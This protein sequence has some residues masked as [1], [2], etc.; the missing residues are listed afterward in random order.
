MRD[1]VRSILDQGRG[2]IGRRDHPELGSALDWA[3]RRGELVAVLAG[4]YATPVDAA[5]LLT[6]ARAARLRDPGC[7]VV[8]ESAAVLM[9]WGEVPEPADLQVASTR[10][11]PHAGFRVERRTIPRRLVR[12]VDDVLTS[13]RALTALDLVDSRGADAVDDAL[14]RGVPLEELNLAL[15]LVRG[16]R[17]HLERRRLVK[18]SAGRPF[19]AAERRAH[20]LLREAR[21]GGW[22]GNREF[23]DVDGN[24]VAVGDL[25]FEVAQVIIEIDG[26]QHLRPEAVARDRVRDLWL[27][28][29]GW[30]VHRIDAAVVF[31]DP[32][33]FVRLVRSL[34]A[35]RRRRA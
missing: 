10:L 7:V 12:R 2:V 23:R 8:R 29:R 15:N 22:V 17:R 5:T 31:N 34:V 21:I 11:R 33:G 6:R 19:S 24:L 1:D 9:G 14:R 20:A 4:V 16:R 30:T 18:Q 13:G 28:T 35:V 25:V 27:G 32:S 3:V 26:R